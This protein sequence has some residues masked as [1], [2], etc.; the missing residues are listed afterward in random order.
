MDIQSLLSKLEQLGQE[1]DAQIENKDQKYLN[2][3]RDTGEF[4][5]VLIKVGAMRHVLEIG[6]SNG[7]STLWIASALPEGGLV[8]TLEILPHKIK[9]A[10]ANFGEAKLDHKINVIQSD[11]CGYF[12]ES[13]SKFDLVFLDADRSL[14]MSVAKEILAC[15]RPGGVLVCDNAVSHRSELQEF[16]DFVAETGE[17][18]TALVP[19]G[20]GEFVACKSA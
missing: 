3:T 10:V 19:I 1:N 14:Y 18:T 8:T 20:K 12:R 11:A 2:I 13:D 7:Y 15:V 16:M 6:T 9:Q 4:L 5:A 17:F